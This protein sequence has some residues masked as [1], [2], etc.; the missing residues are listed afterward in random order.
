MQIACTTG[1]LL[2][3]PLRRLADSQASGPSCSN[4]NDIFN[5]RRA[6]RH[7]NFEQASQDLFYTDR[8]YSAPQAGALNGSNPQRGSMYIQ[9][10]S[11]SNGLS[12]SA[13]TNR[14]LSSPRSSSP[15]TKWN[16]ATPMNGGHHRDGSPGKG[17]VPYMVTLHPYNWAT[18]NN[19][20]S[21]S[22]S[23]DRKQPEVDGPDFQPEDNEDGGVIYR[24]QR[25]SAPP[26]VPQPYAGPLKRG[27]GSLSPT[28]SELPQISFSKSPA[29]SPGYQSD[30]ARQITEPYT[31]KFS[32]RHERVLDNKRFCQRP[33]SLSHVAVPGPSG[34]NM[35]LSSTVTNKAKGKPAGKQSPPWNVSSRK[36]FHCQSKSSTPLRPADNVP[37]T[38]TR[39]KE[40]DLTFQQDDLDMTP[41]YN[42]EQTGTRISGLP[43]SPTQ[44]SAHEL[45]ENHRPMY[46]K[47]A[48]KKTQSCYMGKGA[49]DGSSPR[50]RLSVGATG[51]SRLPVP[52]VISPESPT[53][54]STRSS[55]SFSRELFSPLHDTPDLLQSRHELLELRDAFRGTQSSQNPM[56]EQEAFW[57]PD[58][59]DTSPVQNVSSSPRTC[60]NTSPELERNKDS[61][62]LTSGLLGATDTNMSYSSSPVRFAQTHKT[63]IPDSGR[64]MN[65][66][67]TMHWATGVPLDTKKQHR[68]PTYRHISSSSRVKDKTKGSLVEDNS[69]SSGVSRS[70]RHGDVANRDQTAGSPFSS[71]GLSLS[72]CKK[73]TRRPLPQG[74]LSTTKEKT[75]VD[76]LIE[77]KRQIEKRYRNVTRVEKG[78]TEPLSARTTEHREEKRR[79]VVPVKH[80]PVRDDFATRVP[81]SPR[82]SSTETGRQHGW[83]TLSAKEEELRQGSLERLRAETAILRDEMEKC[84]LWRQKRLDRDESMREAFIGAYDNL[85][86]PLPQG[87][88]NCSGS[89]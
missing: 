69:Q 38:E 65:K 29:T 46:Y 62:R 88:S 5:T 19:S 86:K 15:R 37:S 43:P 3:M 12:R 82:E 79:Q 2:K 44:C 25:R 1:Q 42:K 35:S 33:R 81:R 18:S 64:E 77:E 56:C 67:F 14:R 24:K 47:P 21:Q 58:S 80:P 51:K 11:T 41:L 66:E 34:N 39:D 63:G 4:N 27:Q 22:R 53:L 74:L 54:R 89:Y 6:R 40:K 26:S 59:L 52:S 13:S 20:A 16:S 60:L 23:L 45:E 55:R 78:L 49:N 7:L 84:R 70:A 68:T 83:S 71:L 72:P 10:C 87:G 36:G 31:S 8:R 32:L 57:S 75:T 28:K 30:N 50:R 76:Y 17:P 85:G 61:V 9:G 73:G 48:E